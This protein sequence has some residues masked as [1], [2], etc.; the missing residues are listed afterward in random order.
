MCTSW[1]AD[2]H[3]WEGDLRRSL[4]MQ[5]F[6]SR[7]HFEQARMKIKRGLFSAL[8][9][10][11]TVLIVCWIVARWAPRTAYK[12]LQ[13][14]QSFFVPEDA[15]I[16]GASKGQIQG[17]SDCSYISPLVK[18]RVAAKQKW[19]CALCKQLLDET[20]EI[21]HRTPLY[22]GGHPTNENN[23]QALCKR[24]HAFKTAVSDRL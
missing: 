17:R 12:M 13:H 24:C 6:S 10:M 22:K 23:L 3:P 14:S 4:R 18:K 8:A 2:P 1:Q 15:P 5:P 16:R 19:R 20:F 11:A 9:L 21:D 7:S